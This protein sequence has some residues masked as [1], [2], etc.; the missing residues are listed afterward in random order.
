M[1]R[2]IFDDE[3][4][5]IDLPGQLLELIEHQSRHPFPPQV[6]CNHNLVDENR[7]GR[8]LH[9]YDRHQVSHEFAEQAACR[10]TRVVAVGA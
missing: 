7:V 3:V 9:P 10:W 2:T 4:P 8:D 6:G 1:V 5:P